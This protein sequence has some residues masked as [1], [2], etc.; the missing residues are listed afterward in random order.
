MKK[1]SL[2]IAMILCVTIGG[3]Y[4]TWTYAG[5]KVSDA[6]YE[7]VLRL[8]DA[9]EE[10]AYG[11]YKVESNAKVF[12]DQN[13]VGDYTAVLKFAKNNVEDTRDIFVTVTFTPNTSLATPEIIAGGL[14]SQLSFN[15]LQ[16][17]QVKVS[18]V[19]NEALK[20][21][22][23]YVIDQKAGTLTDVLTFSAPEEI[24]WTKQKDG[25][26]TYTLNEAQLKEKIKLNKDFYIATKAEYD[27]FS[28]A[29]TSNVVIKVTDIHSA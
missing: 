24:N 10:G 22:G 20:S 7:S 26:F 21:H 4:A 17:M 28:A 12:L 11:T 1:L 29:L 9:V 15:V 23:K 14:K 18:Q 5:Q 2:L 25:S 13:A 6:S 3:V 19:N 27:V 16:T 8:T